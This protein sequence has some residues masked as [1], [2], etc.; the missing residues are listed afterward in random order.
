MQE[1]RL[2]GLEVNDDI[3]FNVPTET[4]NP[5]LKG[6][7]RPNSREYSVG[8]NDLKIIGN[9]PDDLDGAYIRNTHN[10]VV[11]P[12][13][14]YHPLDGDGLLHSMRFRDGKC[15]YR[16]RF[17]R[18]TG[19]DAEQSARKALW[20]GMLQPDVYMRRGWGSMGAMKDNAGTDVVVHAGKLYSTMAQGSEPWVLSP[21]TLETLGV[22]QSWAHLLIKE[23]LPAHSKV[24]QSTGDMI[25]FNFSEQPPYLY[26]GVV[27]RA[28]KLVHYVPIDLPGARVPHDIGMTEHYSILHDLPWWFNPELLKHGI[29]KGEFHPEA[30]MRFGV[31]PRFGRSEDVRWFEAKSG[32]MLHVSNCFEDGDWVIQD[33]CRYRNDPGKPPIGQVEGDIYARMMTSLLMANKQSQMYRWMFNMATGEVREFAFDDDFTEYPIVSND[34]VG[35]PY[36]FSY[37]STTKTEV[38]QVEGYKKYDVLNKTYESIELGEGRFG[39]EVVIARPEGSKAEDDGY[40]ITFI[41]D[42]EQDRSECVIMRADDLEGGPICTIILPE[43]ISIG[44]HA[45]WVEG[46]R[47]EGETRVL[48]PSLSGVLSD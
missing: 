48:T 30:P 27:S 14:I 21:V 2:D 8:H 32:W 41:T 43:R 39:S 36:R 19:F 9:V 18:T 22:N 37:N 23:G 10:Q 17:V 24:D 12:A 42:M 29:R 40:L 28:D 16:S 35:Q 15:E 26:Y 25:F 31:I 34:F 33:G 46:D 47:L 20:P 5:W 45:C 38:M 3:F 1:I 11:A 7:W 4:D 6:P 13:A 44:T